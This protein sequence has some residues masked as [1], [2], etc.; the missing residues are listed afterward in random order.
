MHAVSNA[1]T[2]KGIRVGRKSND[3]Q[4]ATFS[5][6]FLAPVPRVERLSNAR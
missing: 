5:A 2:G 6:T 4:S 1:P 3:Q